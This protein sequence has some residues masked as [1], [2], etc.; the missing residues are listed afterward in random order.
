LTAAASPFDQ[1]RRRRA[2]LREVRSSRAAQRGAHA[3]QGRGR[4]GPGEAGQGCPRVHAGAAAAQL[5]RWYTGV[6]APR[7]SLGWL[8]EGRPCAPAARSH[9]GEALSS[10]ARRRP[11]GERGAGVAVLRGWLVGG[12]GAQAAGANATACAHP[13]DRGKEE[14]AEERGR[15]GRVGGCSP[16]AGPRPPGPG[17]SSVLVR[18]HPVPA[19]GRLAVSRAC[20]Q[21]YNSHLQLASG[22]RGAPWTP[23]HGAPSTWHFVAAGRE[24]VPESVHLGLLGL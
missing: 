10:R 2:G 1:G 23:V 20:G 18:V 12:R 11:C 24:L 4:W 16:R 7:R 3:W 19:A 15:E 14:A 8:E 13:G 6:P 17:W 5:C 21:L 9:V 22:K